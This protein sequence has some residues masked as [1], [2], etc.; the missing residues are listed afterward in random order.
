[1]NPHMKAQRIAGNKKVTGSIVKIFATEKE[2]I[3]ED[4]SFGDF[5]QVDN[6]NLVS[7]SIHQV[8]TTDLPFPSGSYLEG[9]F[10]AL[11]VNNKVT[12]VYY[13]GEILVE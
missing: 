13:N 4:C 12:V 2:T 6:F 1:M 8:N 9:P 7:S 5:I 3:L 11:K 10:A